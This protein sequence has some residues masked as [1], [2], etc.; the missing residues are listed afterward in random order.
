MDFKDF[1]DFMLAQHD[2]FGDMVAEMVGDAFTH[3]V[4]A[5]ANATVTAVGTARDHMQCSPSVMG[6]VESVVCVQPHIVHV[7]PEE[8]SVLGWILDLMFPP[9]PAPPVAPPPAHTFTV[10]VEDLA[11]HVGLLLLAA[12]MLMLWLKVPMQRYQKVA[13]RKAARLRRSSRELYSG[14]NYD[15]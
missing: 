7:E 11:Q 10:P 15:C 5:A 6:E 2:P 13:D 8:P 14:V 1:E 3:A 12:L 4:M 9:L